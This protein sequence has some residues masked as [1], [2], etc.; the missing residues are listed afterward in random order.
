M[1]LEYNHVNPDRDIVPQGRY[2]ICVYKFAPCGACDIFRPDGRYVGSVHLDRLADLRRRFDAAQ[3]ADGAL[4]A[5]FAMTALKGGGTS[6]PAAPC[7]RQTVQSKLQ[8]EKDWPAG[9]A[10]MAPCYLPSSISPL[11]RLNGARRRS[12]FVHA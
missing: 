10:L 2:T 11:A 7:H 6:L 4:A 3:Q 9:T 5:R 1:P 12:L 8:Y